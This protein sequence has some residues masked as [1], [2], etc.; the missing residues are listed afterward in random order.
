MISEFKGPFRFL[1]NF[2]NV[3][4]TLDGVK[5]PTVEHAYQAA[6]T[7]P[8]NRVPFLNCERPGEAKRLGR[9]VPMRSDWE[10]VKLD[11]MY[12]LVKE[13][14]ASNPILNRWL[15]NTGT[16]TLVEGNT[17]GDCFWG[18]CNGK[19]EN[20]LGKILMRVREELKK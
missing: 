6:K 8:E 15:Q 1:S 20:H 5:Y 18:V 16:Q 19:G 10:S 12:Q 4:V 7:S 11:V 13:K 2:W 9:K 14:F 3:E 17:W